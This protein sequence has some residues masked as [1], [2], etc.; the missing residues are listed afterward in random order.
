MTLAVTGIEFSKKCDP[1]HALVIS[2]IDVLLKQSIV[3]VAVGVVVPVA[4]EIVT[5]PDNITAPFHGSVELSCIATGN[6]QPTILWY[7]DNRRLFDTAADP[8]ILPISQLDLVDR[9]FYFCE[10]SNSAGRVISRTIIVNIEGT[11]V[12]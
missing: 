11:K 9:G 1:H 10:A 4:P 6:P 5:P 7:K 2:G 8:S 12:L 3:F